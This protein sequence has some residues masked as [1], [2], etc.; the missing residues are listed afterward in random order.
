MGSFFR[1]T[2]ESRA[3]SQ[4]FDRWLGQ[5][6]AGKAGDERDA[7]LAAWASAPA[8]TAAH[9]REEHLLP[10]LVAA[11]AAGDDTGLQIPH[12]VMM[13]ATISSFQFG[14]G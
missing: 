5:T 1:S 14:S 10:L 8:G 12:G 7:L 4:S 6:C 11:G 2:A 3:A 13:G 9:P